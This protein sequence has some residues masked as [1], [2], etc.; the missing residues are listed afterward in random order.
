MANWTRR[1]TASAPI[2]ARGG[3]GR[4]E[5]PS[6]QRAAER[7]IALRVCCSCS[8]LPAPNGSRR[9]PQTGAPSWRAQIGPGNSTSSATRA[10]DA[11]LQQVDGT[12]R[13]N[14]VRCSLTGSTAVHDPHEQLMWKWPHSVQHIAEMRHGVDEHVRTMGEHVRISRTSVQRS[15]FHRRPRGAAPCRGSRTPPRQ[16]LAGAIGSCL[17]AR[18][19]LLRAVRPS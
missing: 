2:A 3:S 11:L 8:K 19:A 9:V 13:V 4:R 6:S 14:R 16:L 15:A 7:Q 1:P 10:H 5:Y 12:T 18:R 17:G